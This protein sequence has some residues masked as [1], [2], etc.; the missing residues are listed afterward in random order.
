MRFRVGILA[1]VVLTACPDDELREGADA[2]PGSGMPTTAD[3]ESESESSV[4]SPTSAATQSPTTAP[5]TSASGPSSGPEP[6]ESSAN[7]SSSGGSDTDNGLLQ[8]T[9]GVRFVSFGDAG[10]GNEAQQRVANAA[11]VVCQ[12]RGCN[13]GLMLGDNFYD[14][15]VTSITDQQFVDKFETIY[16]G[17]D[18]P[19]YVVLGNHDYGAL[20]SDWARG[21]YQV[22]YSDTS[23]KW[24]M[25][26]FWYTFTSAS[27]GTQFFAFDTQR[28][29]FNHQ[30]NDQRDW[31]AQEM[32]ASQSSWK[33]AFAHHPYISNG[34]HGNA[35]NYEG[36]P[37]IPVISGVHVKAF[38]DDLVCGQAQIYIS[39]HDHNRQAFDPVCGTYFFVSGA[40]A[41][42]SEFAF[43]DD[44]PT[45][46]GD[47]T[48][49][50]FLWVEILDENMTAAFYDLDGNLD[51]EMMAS[52]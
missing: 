28:M 52:L 47:D 24:T 11:E 31:F 51:H 50:G 3:A 22:Q 10:E 41:K 38:I 8:E 42:T 36:F 49:A 2:G 30:V 39:G 14:E 46:W 45:L 43:R 37:G 17:L 27:G 7:P 1:S 5:S 34:E 21:D 4:S 25:P 19:F 20:A 48:R 6:S 29:M 33:V 12:D 16:E 9:E 35:G 44:N 23:D 32:T 26:H 15:G 18:M 40:A 13:F